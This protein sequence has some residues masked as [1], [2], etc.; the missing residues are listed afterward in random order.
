VA[1][2]IE[3]KGA[4]SLPHVFEQL[5]YVRK[6]RPEYQHLL[7]SLNQM[8]GPKTLEKA[9][10][11]SNGMLTK[12]EKEALEKQHDIRVSEVLYCEATTPIPDLRKYL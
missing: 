5:V 10:I 4:G 12:P 2:L 9:V 1:I 6:K 3:L 7:A 8:P 11:V